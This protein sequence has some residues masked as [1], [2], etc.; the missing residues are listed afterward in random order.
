MHP[1]N[2]ALSLPYISCTCRIVKFLCWFYFA[3]FERSDETVCLRFGNMKK[4]LVSRSVLECAIMCTNLKTCLSFYQE[5]D[6][7]VCHLFDLIEET[8]MP[9]G[10]DCYDGIYFESSVIVD[11]LLARGE[12]NCLT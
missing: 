12:E 5:K 6:T 8:S 10:T 9:D 3:D 4:S 1:K 7:F 2:Q 11:E